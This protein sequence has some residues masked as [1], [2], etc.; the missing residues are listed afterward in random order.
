MLNCP[1]VS[2]INLISDTITKP[3][4]PMLIAMMHAEVG[5]DVFG[6]DPNINA[7]EAKAAAMF[8]MEAALFCPSGTMTNQI[9]IKAHTQP[10]EEVICDE[11][12]HIFQ[13]EAGGYAFHSGVAVNLL[14]GEYGLLTADMVEKAIRP[15]FDWTPHSSLV[16]LENTCNHGG[17][18]FYTLKQVKPIAKLCKKK[19]LKLHLD[20]ARLFNALVETGETTAEWGA[21]FHSISI[22]LSKGLGAPVGSLLLGEKDFIKKARR[23]RKAFGGGM[24]QG[25]F[26][27]A[28]GIY[29]LDNHV[30]RLK[31]DN[32][33]A[34]KIGAILKGLPYVENLRPVMT[35]I[36]IFDV[37]SPLTGD[38]FLQ[39]LSAKGVQAVLFGPN[40]VRFVTHLHITSAMV[41]ELIT[42]LKN[43]E[44]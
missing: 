1:F 44:I 39:K 14:R 20:G 43:L 24:R 2:M 7:L 40:T 10:L 26:L 16:V 18:S 23:L 6:S 33:N 30:H 32:D 37:K 28:A 42:I 9:A 12:S 8:G 29:A 41:A 5:D 22:C 25:G 34:K 31:E 21:Q 4:P 3:T 11:K 13:S 17:G 36:V 15:K 35:N 38:I 27:A 19:G